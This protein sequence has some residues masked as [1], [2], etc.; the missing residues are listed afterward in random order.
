M[1]FDIDVA[2]VLVFLVVN[3]AAGLY[4][5]KGKT[6]LREY[7]VGNKDFTTG[8]LTATIIATCIGGGFF[9][10]AI[11]ESYKQ[12]LYFIIPAIGEPL[13]LIM[14]GYFLIP[15]MAEFLG[16]LSVAD[17]MGN[18]Y[19]K[20]VR[21]ISA[22][23]GILLCIGI[24]AL[25][26][27]VGASILGIF[28]KV[29][30]FY[31]TLLC[32]VIVTVYSAFGGVKAVTF[33]DI[34]QFFTFGT[35]IPIISL[36]I[37]G[38][39]N[40]PY[41]AFTTLTQSPLF[42]Y[43]QVFDFSNVKFVN[44]LFLLIFFLVPGF[45][46]VFFQR[47]I[48]AKNIIQARRAFIIGGIICLV[49]LLIISWVGILLLSS[50]PNIEP[51]NLLPYII[52]TYSYAGLKGLTAIGILAVIMSTADSYINSAAVL[53]TNDILKPLKIKKI[54]LFNDLT[55]A[56]IFSFAIGSVG[57]FVAFKSSTVLKLLLFTFSFYAPIVSAPLLLTILGFRSTAVPVL[58]GITAGSLAVII[59]N[60]VK[61]SDDVIP[62]LSMMVNIIF[63]ITSH[64]LL[65]QPGGW[66]GVKC[67]EP[68]NIMRTERKRKINK[69]IKSIKKFNFIDFCKNNSPKEEYI[70]SFFGLFC[71]ISV[72]STMYSMPKEMQQQN[73]QLIEFI[74]HTV[75][76][77]SSIFLTYPIWPALFK[78]EKFIII[79][80]N[81]AIPYVLLFSPM[82]LVIISNFGQFQ[83]MILM[84]N[85][86]I[87][88][89]LLRWQLV[90]PMMI[91]SVISATEFYKWFIGGEVVN[92]DIGTLQFK[93]MYLLL[94]VSSALI[95]F[96]KPKQTYAEL[97]EVLKGEWE[98]KL[99]KL[100]QEL[101]KVA[102]HQEEFFGRIDTPEKKQFHTLR[103]Q[104][105]ELYEKL[106]TAHG[107]QQISDITKNIY[108]ATRQIEAGASYLSTLIYR[109][110][111]QVDIK[112]TK[113]NI[114]Q[115]INEVIDDCQK[116]SQ[117]DFYVISEYKIKHQ[118]ILCDKEKLTQVIESMLMYAVKNS[119]NN[120]PINILLEDDTLLFNLNIS[121]T[122]KAKK[123]IESIRFTI[124]DQ[125]NKLTEEEY[126]AI[127]HPTFRSTDHLAFIECYNIIYAHYGH[128]E[129]KNNQDKGICYTF[130][131][132][133]NIKE[134]RP[135]V[136]DIIDSRT[137]NLQ[138][139]AAIFLKEQKEGVLNIAQR[140]LKAG[141]DLNTIEK[142]TLLSK[143]E[144][145]SIR[146]D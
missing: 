106:Q 132:P 79:A 71:I 67:P 113:V 31:A 48:M 77:Y 7:A 82:L 30:G 137:S 26:F 29:S 38:T 114:I 72:F 127:F 125:G 96:L 1:H 140:L 74:N 92:L 12:G 120:D 3:L 43:K 89:I 75:L 35:I 42:D 60:I 90:I 117:Q 126:E 6:S 62:A 37:W 136:M 59:C 27:K 16:D 41:A 28:F 5:G 116:L 32:A 128:F 139:I 144:I 111:N 102:Q 34:I 81:M 108:E 52:S 99:T 95:A 135:K 83:L 112:L 18:L 55:L 141:V 22:I 73:R 23:S 115:L 104:I 101:I 94:L 88:A 70:Y 91:I 119:V 19:G 76:L 61:I 40:D 44:T 14:I 2:I 57:F 87:I 105:K 47:I 143:E 138:K 84:V 49:L 63:L 9:S 68:I 145:I 54:N 66:V 51:N 45:Q 103:L 65:K 21:I 109:V 46:P 98:T 142:V 24:I 130:S 86:I 122:T 8:T 129:V 85:I 39:L 53:F 36:S 4:Y 50:N 118:E 110:R 134:I 25:Q 97:S 131:I 78:K 13:C 121:D 58:I 15:R 133:A 10:G 17:A 107:K 69:L 64:Y 100:T 93:I 146:Q 56:C 20:Y 80:W 11:T 123:S 33:T 124:I